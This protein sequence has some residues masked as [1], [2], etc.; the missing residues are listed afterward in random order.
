MHGRVTFNKALFA[1]LTIL[2][3]RHCIYLQAPQTTSCANQ[4]HQGHFMKTRGLQCTPCMYSWRLLWL[5]I[6]VDP[7]WPD[8]RTS[9]AHQ[10][11]RLRN[12]GAD[13][14]R[15]LRRLNTKVWAASGHQA[16]HNAFVGQFPDRTFDGA[17]PF[18]LPG[19]CEGNFSSN[20][21]LTD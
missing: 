9:H 4:H 6:S 18:R 21:G 10:S 15:A 17:A 13:P 3:G 8:I 16:D 20:N 5:T 12:A 2:A 19:T 1:E 7:L 11:P 14:A